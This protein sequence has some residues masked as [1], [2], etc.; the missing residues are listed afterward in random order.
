MAFRSDQELR[1]YARGLIDERKMAAARG[2]D[3]QVAAVT[4]ELR[5]IGAEAETPR[6]AATKRAPKSKTGEKR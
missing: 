6:Q 1:D 4:A 3:A 5:R 2:D